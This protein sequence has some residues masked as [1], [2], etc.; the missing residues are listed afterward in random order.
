MRPGV[1]GIFHLHGGLGLL[2]GVIEMFIIFFYIFGLIIHAI[3][4]IL[5][6]YQNVH[7]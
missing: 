6:P 4:F 7:S 5:V 3:S 1:R 2:A